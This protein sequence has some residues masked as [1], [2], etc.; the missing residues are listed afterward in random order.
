MTSLG[1]WIAVALLAHVAA[2]WVIK[3]VS[4][5]RVG[6]GGASDPMYWVTPT[7]S[8]KVVQTRGVRAAHPSGNSKNA[9]A[10]GSAARATAK[11]P[12]AAHPYLRHVYEA[13]LSRQAELTDTGPLD[14]SKRVEVEFSIE[15]DGQIRDVRLASS[16]QN[17]SVDLMAL[18]AIRS[19]DRVDPIP[20][21][22]LPTTSERFLHLRLPLEFVR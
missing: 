1:R 14:G 13:I 5:P 10:R 11:G 12:D 4:T 6:L 8:A 20:E 2:L 18:S 3:T 16:S 19:I 9:P 15:P 17:P 22:L 7:P 21:A